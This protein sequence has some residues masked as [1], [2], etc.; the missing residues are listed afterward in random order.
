MA[1]TSRLYRIFAR[2]RVQARAA[3]S[4]IDPGCS[5]CAAL[6]NEHIQVENEKLHLE[7]E[8]GKANERIVELEAR[9]GVQQ[10]RIIDLA[11]EREKRTQKPLGSS[12]PSSK[13]NFK[14]MPK[15]MSE[16]KR[17]APKRGIRATEESDSKT[18][19]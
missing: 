18:V 13:E 19:R 11:K 12:T 4:G 17:V 3:Q 7:G 10:K 6:L 9:L 15:R 8:L 5:S 16:R 2:D 1:I 14:K